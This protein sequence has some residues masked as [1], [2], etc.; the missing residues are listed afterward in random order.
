MDQLEGRTAV[1]TG[2]ASGIGLALAR[3]L[4]DAGMNVALADVDEDALRPAA[5]SLD[6]SASRVT[7][8]RTDVSVYSQMVE[9][10][11]WVEERFGP[12]HVLCNNAG[13][14]GYRG[15]PLWQASDADWAWTM[16]VN[17]WGVVH[18][19]RAFLPGMLQRGA[20]GHIVNTCSAAALT[21]PNNMY[22]ITKHAVL[23]LTEAID[24]Q[25][26]AENSVIGVTALIPDLVSTQFFARRHRDDTGVEASDELRDGAAERA[27]KDA[28]LRE[29][30]ASPDVVA[31]RALTAIREN[32][33]YALTHESSK[34]YLRSRAE[35]ILDSLS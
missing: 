19:V 31:A 21:K 28:L 18:G 8:R 26:R 7:W 35:A 9:L 29:Q 14:D 12:T 27:E 2:A 16:G 23:A 5:E 17:Y 24:A 15:G 11:T 20:P 30:G 10:A 1:V 13:V 3:A 34:D 25:L 6:R 22:G 33:L 4:H 32:Q